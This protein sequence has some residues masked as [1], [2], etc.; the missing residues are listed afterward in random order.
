MDGTLIS[1][2]PLSRAASTD[3]VMMPAWMR[4]SAP[5]L[6][7]LLVPTVLRLRS[8]SALEACKAPLLKLSEVA[9][10]NFLI[11]MLLILRATRL[12]MTIDL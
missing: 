6:T 11:W 2:T 4:T 5:L 8:T 7:S 10:A 12:S 3:F 1:Q 9:P